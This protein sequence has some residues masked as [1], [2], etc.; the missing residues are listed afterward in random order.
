MRRYRFWKSALSFLPC[1]SSQAVAGN[2]WHADH[3]LP[4]FRGGGACEM[5]NLRTLCVA[6]HA[7]VTAKQMR[8]LAAERRRAKAGTADIRTVIAKAAAGTKRGAK[9]AAGA[10]AGGKR[11]GKGADSSGGAG[12]TG[13]SAPGAEDGARNDNGSA[14]GAAALS[15]GV[16]RS[17]P[18]YVDDSG[19]D[20][21][22]TAPARR[23]AAAVGRQATAE[24]GGRCLKAWPIARQRSAP[25]RNVI[26]LTVEADEDEDAEWEV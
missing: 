19:D 20:K 6:C 1:F 21:P 15:K 2:A 7:E 16:K 8:D 22:S 13:A 9:S 10:A 4:V 11:G 12:S 3:I 18:A 25:D 24:A 5:D 26:D 14:L 17:R 23:A